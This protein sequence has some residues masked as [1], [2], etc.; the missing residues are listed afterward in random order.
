MALTPDE[1]QSRL[2][3]LISQWESKF[4]PLVLAATEIRGIM[5]V[6]IFERSK[7]T[8]G[9]SLPSKPYSTKPAYF[10]PKGLPRV[11]SQLQI[12]KRGSRIKSVYAEGGYSQLKSVLGRPPLELTNSLDSAFNNLLNDNPLRVQGDSVAIVVPNSEAGKIEGLEN[13][14]GTIFQMSDEE[15]DLFFE[16]LS[17]YIADAINKALE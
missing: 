3:A 15:T 1:I 12:G 13:L 8:S 14:Y 9:T 7:N 6:R 10:S 11:P 2:D 5:G 17:E 4:S 16:I